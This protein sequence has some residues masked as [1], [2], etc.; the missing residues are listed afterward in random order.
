VKTEEKVIRIGYQKSGALLLVKNEG[1][2]E[3]RLVPPE[4]IDEQQEAADTFFRLDVIPKNIQVARNVY[5]T[6]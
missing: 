5:H 2:L 6:E 3:K 1:T 4:M